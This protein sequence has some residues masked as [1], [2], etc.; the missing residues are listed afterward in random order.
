MIHPFLTDFSFVGEVLVKFAAKISPIG[1]LKNHKRGTRYLPGGLRYY[2]QTAGHHGVGI[3]PSCL[4][5]ETFSKLPAKGG[6]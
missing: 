1:F 4:P 5:I 3:I 6:E 2:H